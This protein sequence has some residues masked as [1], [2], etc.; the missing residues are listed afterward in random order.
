M[1]ARPLLSPCWCLL[2]SVLACQ[3]LTQCAHPKKSASHPV[4]P[5]AGWY[6]ASKG[7]LTY[8]PKGSVLPASSRHEPGAFVYLA[9]RRTRFYIPPNAMA[10]HRQALQMRKASLSASQ[11]HLNSPKNTILW[12]G[13]RLLQVSLTSVVVVG[14]MVVGP[15]E[16]DVFENIWF[17]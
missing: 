13:K 8:C 16:A 15:S 7:P 10:H 14:I 4:P 11:S 6:I 2:I 12:V 17:D 5:D 9:G 3:C 1:N